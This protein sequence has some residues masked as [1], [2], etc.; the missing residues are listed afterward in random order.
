MSGQQTERLC[1]ADFSEH[2]Q[3]NSLLGACW[4][5]SGGEYQISQLKSSLGLTSFK[6]ALALGVVEALEVNTNPVI[7]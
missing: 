3:F 1:R 4:L 7:R 2:W 6:P 5:R